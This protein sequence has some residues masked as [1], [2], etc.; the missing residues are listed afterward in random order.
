MHYSKW[1]KVYC[2]WILK[3]H[4]HI[5]TLTLSLSKYTVEIK[6]LQLLL[7]ASDHGFVNLVLI[8][9]V[10][11]SVVTQCS[12]Y[13]LANHSHTDIRFLYALFSNTSQSRRPQKPYHRRLNFPSV[14]QHRIA[15]DK[16]FSVTQLKSLQQ[17]KC[18]L[19]NDSGLQGTNF[20]AFAINSCKYTYKMQS[21]FPLTNTNA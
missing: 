5:S 1:V 18:S 20:T 12:I 8:K 21:V 11:N 10:Q 19:Q 9:H 15:T 16:Y 6:L 4:E 3:A 2:K 17:V 7:K 13:P 14:S